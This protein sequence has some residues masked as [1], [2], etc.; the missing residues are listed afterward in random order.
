MT[1]K[2]SVE[3]YALT[4]SIQKLDLQGKYMSDL[5]EETKK[6][7]SDNGTIARQIKKQY[8]GNTTWL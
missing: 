3:T 6:Q 5:Q 8:D 1:M 2:D 7:K 4:G